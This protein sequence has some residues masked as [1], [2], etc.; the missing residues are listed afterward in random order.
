MA[1]PFLERENRATQGYPYIEIGRK[2][3]CS[4]AHMHEEIEIVYVKEGSVEAFVGGEAVL[5]EAG[6]ICIV[7]P[8]E[9]HS[10]GGNTRSVVNLFKLYAG[11]ELHAVRLRRGPK[12]MPTHYRHH[13]FFE[14]L[15]EIEKEHLKRR[16]GYTYAVPMQVL[17][18]KLMLLR[19]LMVYTLTEREGA[20]VEKRCDFL[21]R[22][23][24]FL[25]EH[26]TE[27]ISLAS[28][29][30]AMHYS[31]SYFAH[32]F[33]EIAGQSFFEYVTLFRLD[34]AKERL[35]GG[36]SILDTALECGF[37]SV[38]SFYRAFRKYCGASPRAYCAPEA[39]EI[40]S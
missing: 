27:Q 32:R 16:P 5:L 6:D 34:E 11:G 17:N 29:A 30:E 31:R 8:Y 37:G 39:E 33:R 14:V 40:L 24:A 15:L 36:A 26:Y 23:D 10:Y 2:N 21:C 22:F 3:L 25:K 4:R 12:L 7:M 9:V 13:D 20:L 19:S 35:R 1:E 38:R 28:A 18:F